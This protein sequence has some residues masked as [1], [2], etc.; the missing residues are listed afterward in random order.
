M[1]YSQ[2]FNNQL[3]YNSPAVGNFTGD[4]SWQMVMVMRGSNST[5]SVHLSPT[6]MTILEVRQSTNDPPDWGQF[7]DTANHYAVES[8]SDV[9]PEPDYHGV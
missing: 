3:F 8:R 1:I 9:R 7:R 6:T 5:L 2:T 4:G